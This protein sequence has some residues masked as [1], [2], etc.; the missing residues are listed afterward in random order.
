MADTKSETDIPIAK[1]ALEKKLIDKEQLDRCLEL[2]K[3]SRKIGLQTTIEE[4]LVKQGLLSDTKVQELQEI[5]QMVDGGK[6]FGTYRLGRLIGQ[7]GMGKVYE[8]VHEIMGRNVAIKVISA[9]FTEDK[10]NTARFYQEIRALAKLSHPN[11]VIIYE[12]GMVNRR[13]YF[14][15]EYL[16]GPSLHAHV[17]SRKIL[18]EKEALKIVRAT[19]K[20][21]GHAHARNIVHRDVK[22]ENIIFDE[23]GA[24]KLTDFGL[25]MHH[26]ADHMT[27]TQEG[28]MVGSFYYTSPEQ[29][30]GRRDIDARSDIYSLGATLYFALTGHTLYDGSSPQEI[31]TKHMKGRYLPPKHYNPHVSRRT[32]GILKKMIAVNREKRFQSMD[33]V[34]DA[35]DGNTLM[36]KIMLIGSLASCGAL[37]FILG[38]LFERFFHI[39]K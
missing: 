2:V 15:M 27:L 26:D 7:G 10:N 11:I 30:D 25:V 39:F 29:I 24:P 3:K 19:A 13:H 32:A 23:T 16:S 38:M 6:A 1:L 20:A 37:L 8:A 36:H 4:V 5:N 9:K 18:D 31:L 22:P 21:L 12:A 28:M 14:A 34:V 35:I 33:D 17:A